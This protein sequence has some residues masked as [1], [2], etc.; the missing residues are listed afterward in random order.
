MTKQTGL[1]CSD[2]IPKECK[3]YCC[4]PVPVPKH[5]YY[6]NLAKRCRPVIEEIDMTDMI[7]PQTGESKCT[8]L[9]EAFQCQIYDDRPEPCRAF[10]KID[11][12]LMQCPFMDK[13]GTRRTSKD[14]KKV[15]REFGQALADAQ[16]LS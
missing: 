2:F 8:F 9:S 3:A 7:L 13:N 16:H 6:A 4:G 12:P 10:G 1:T 15:E 11:S 5:I 14:R